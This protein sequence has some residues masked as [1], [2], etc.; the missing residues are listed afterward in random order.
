MG[1]GN[2]SSA[3]LDPRAAR[4]ALSVAR[5][6]EKVDLLLSAPDPEALVQGG[7]AEARAE[8]GDAAAPAEGA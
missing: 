5:G 8:R 4:Q 7:A 1:S 2:G 3:V 6:K